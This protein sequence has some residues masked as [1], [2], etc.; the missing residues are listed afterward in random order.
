MAAFYAIYT[1]SLSSTVR[2]SNVTENRQKGLYRIYFIHMNRAF[3]GGSSVPTSE[4]KTNSLCFDLFYVFLSCFYLWQIC[5][6]FQMWAYV[7]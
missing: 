7:L 3:K 5:V 6:Y 2:S 1:K 4:K